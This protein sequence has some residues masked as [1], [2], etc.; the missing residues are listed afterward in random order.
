MGEGEPW[1]LLVMFGHTYYPLSI[2]N[3]FNKNDLHETILGVDPRQISRRDTISLELA[4][5][6]RLPFLGSRLIMKLAHALQKT[7]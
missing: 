2:V 4:T 3:L 1:S 5:R 7:M 6:A